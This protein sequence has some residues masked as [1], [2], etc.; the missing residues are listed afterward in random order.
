[1]GTGLV[2]CVRR[3]TPTDRHRFHISVA[4]MSTPWSG[5]TFTPGSGTAAN[6]S[7]T[8]CSTAT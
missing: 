7:A 5:G 6:S 1:M 4:S 2:P 8:A 3:A